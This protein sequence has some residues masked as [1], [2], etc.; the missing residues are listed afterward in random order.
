MAGTQIDTSSSTTTSA[1]M[2][3][4]VQ[5]SFI[6]AIRLTKIFKNATSKDWDYET[7][8]FKTTKVGGVFT[9]NGKEADKHRIKEALAAGQ[10]EKDGLNAHVST[11]GMEDGNDDD[12]IFIIPATLPP[13]SG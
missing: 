10:Y 12:D 1:S 3:A 8:F 13:S 6:F 7:L 11:V 9:D 4:K 2:A 5:T